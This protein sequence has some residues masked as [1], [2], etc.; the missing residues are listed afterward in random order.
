[1]FRNYDK[2]SLENILSLNGL[3]QLH[4]EMI[5]SNCIQ[6]YEIKKK[7][8]LVILHTYLQSN[9]F[10]QKYKLYKLNCLFSC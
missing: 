4:N 5:Y 1:M 7:K 6:D 2:K 3:N 9:K 10:N 8:L